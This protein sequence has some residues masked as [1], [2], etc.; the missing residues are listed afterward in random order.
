MLVAAGCD[1]YL[2]VW[3][4]RKKGLF[5]LSDNLEEEIHSISL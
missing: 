4:L 2:G 1:G 3:D 5:A